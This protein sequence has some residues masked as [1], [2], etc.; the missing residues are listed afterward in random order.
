[1]SKIHLFSKKLIQWYKN[2]ARAL[3]WRKTRDP[4]KIWISEVM[5]QQTTVNAVI[6]FYLRW[7]KTFPTIQSVCR[8]PLQKTLRLWQGL[9][10]YH[11]AKNIHETAKLVARQFNK[12]IPDDPE[13]LKRLP[14]FGPYT[15]G[16]VLSI[17]FNRR[18]PIIDANVRRV[19]MRQLAIQGHADTRV[20]RRLSS[21]LEDVMPYEDMSS[22][23]QGLMELGALICRSKTPLCPNC[24]VNQ[25]CKAHDKGL[26][27]IIPQPKTKV[28]RKIKSVV[29]IVRKDNRYLIQKRPPKG[30]L[31]N[32]WEFP[33]GKVRRKE[34]LKDA[35]RREIKEEL[36]CSVTRSHKIM[37]IKHYYTQFCVDLNV[38]QCRL[39]NLPVLQKTQRWVKRSEFH[40]YPMP[41]GTVRIIEQ[42][43]NL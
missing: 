3:P 8:A 30:L 2:N 9:G 18:Y 38:Y 7:V 6:P 14:G 24:P 36:D 1:M 41:S 34:S 27:E 19:L 33:G 26:Q 15:I 22:F 11:R 20:D 37:N 31:A 13:I 40:R 43:E 10:Y 39:N 21:Y 42:L 28:I 17:A 16:A 35:L 5:L 32:L 25:S 29:A 23:N 12:K 4:Y